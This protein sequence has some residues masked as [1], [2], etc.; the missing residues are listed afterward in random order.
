M[1]KHAIY[2]DTFSYNGGVSSDPPFAC[3]QRAETDGKPAPA[4]QQRRDSEENRPD[5]L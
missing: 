2:N 4:I 1:G 5:L 3:D